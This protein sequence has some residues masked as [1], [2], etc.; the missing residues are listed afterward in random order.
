MIAV[1]KLPLAVGVQPSLESRKSSICLHSSRCPF[2]VVH[3]IDGVSGGLLYEWSP[4][5]SHGDVV[6]DWHCLFVWAGRVVRR[7]VIIACNLVLFRL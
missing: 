2:N 5:W 4:L 3:P 6:A 7:N 1:S